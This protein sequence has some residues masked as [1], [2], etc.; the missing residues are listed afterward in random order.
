[1]FKAF[2]EN[3][4]VDRLLK[5]RSSSGL[6]RKTTDPKAEGFKCVKAKFSRVLYIQQSCTCT[7]DEV[8]KHS[9]SMMYLS[10]KKWNHKFTIDRK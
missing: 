9:P 4:F 8:R 1:M 7:G 3:M 2:L 6:K 10:C 5:G